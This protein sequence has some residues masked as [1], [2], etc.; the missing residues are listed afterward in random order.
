MSAHR[1]WLQRPGRRGGRRHPHAIRRRQ[2]PARRTRDPR[3]PSARRRPRALRLRPSY[4]FELLG[5]HRAGPYLHQRPPSTTWPSWPMP[6]AA[7][8]RADP[9][10][11][12][13]VVSQ[14]V[15][16]P[17]EG[18][19]LHDLSDRERELFNPVVPTREL[20]HRLPRRFVA[21]Q[22]AGTER[23]H[24]RRPMPAGGRKELARNCPNV[25]VQ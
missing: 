19:A 7:S 16:R 17:R 11:N 13:V 23:R 10:S 21:P 15:G 24:L 8:D 3:P 20:R 1:P 4:A 25:V 22:E 9:C 12:P 2:R 6:S 18:P 14:L 5:E